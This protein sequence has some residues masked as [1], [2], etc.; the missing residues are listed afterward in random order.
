MADVRDVHAAG[1]RGDL[2][3]GAIRSLGIVLLFWMAGCANVWNF[4]PFGAED[5]GYDATTGDGGNGADVAVDGPRPDAQTV[6]SPA[7]W[8]SWRATPTPGLRASIR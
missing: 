2:T 6:P 7:R 4:E 5:G 8:A 1:G 3:F